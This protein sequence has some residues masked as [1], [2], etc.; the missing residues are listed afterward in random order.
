MAGVYKRPL[1]L[2][3]LA[4][5]W[6]YIADDSER[7]ADKFLTLLDSKLELLSTQARMGRDRPDLLP[8][9]RSF[10]IDRYLVFYQP[11]PDGVELIR[12]MHSARDIDPSDFDPGTN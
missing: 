8:S 12:V 4:E 7:N 5:I 1:A 11:V 6:S 10:L 9:L 2:A 3:D